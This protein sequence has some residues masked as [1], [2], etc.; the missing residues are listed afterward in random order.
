MNTGGRVLFKSGSRV[1]Y[2]TIDGRVSNDIYTINSEDTS[3]NVRSDRKGLIT[4]KQEGGPRTLQVH[5]RRILPLSIDNKAPVVQ[6]NDKYRVIC[7]ECGHLLDFT[8]RPHED[9]LECNCG[10]T[11]DL[12]WLNEEPQKPLKRKS[13]ETTMIEETA[14]AEET[15]KSKT[16]RTRMPQYQP[17]PVNFTELA[18]LPNCELWTKGNVKFDHVKIDVKAHI[19][20]YTEGDV[21]KKLCFNTYDGALGK[22][23]KELPI[24]NKDDKAWFSVKDP[25]KARSK[26]AKDGYVLQ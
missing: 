20:L 22:K 1:R 14:T 11:V 15:A 19:L 13:Q 10:I 17:E 23:S 6:S 21:C 26:F 9:K 3:Q 5:A 2:L 18:N 4:I 24:S 8:E 12:Y 25:A 16:A 7:P